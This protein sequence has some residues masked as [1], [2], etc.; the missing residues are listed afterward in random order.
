VAQYATAL[1]GTPVELIPSLGSWGDHCLPLARLRE[2]AHAAYAG[3]ATGLCRWDDD[4]SLA[5]ARL[6][7]PEVQRLRCTTYLPPQDNALVEIGGLTL[8]PFA[9]G[10]GY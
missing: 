7:A 4:L 5:R 6:D 10:I 9:P 1:A 3:G 8:D 2:R